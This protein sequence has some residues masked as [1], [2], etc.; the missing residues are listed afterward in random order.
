MLTRHFHGGEGMVTSKELMERT[1]ISRATINNYIALGIL[2][3]AELRR[4]SAA[5]S[6]AP[7]IGYFPDKAIETV[8]T[9]RRLRAEG[10]S[11]DE[12]TLLLKDRKA[13]K[14]DAV[15]MAVGAPASVVSLADHSPNL[16]R[17]TLDQLDYP[18]Y[19]VNNNFEVE[20]WNGYAEEDLFGPDLT[21]NGDIS[22][23]SV[24]KLLGTRPGLA[25]AESWDEILD[26]HFS[27]AKN[28]MPKKALLQLDGEVEAEIFDSLVGAYDQ[29]EVDS[30]RALRQ[31][32][33]N[34]AARADAPRA[35]NLYASFFREGVFLT[36]VPL[37]A[38]RD[39]LLAFLSRRDIV[40]REL[41]KSRRPYL[42]PLAVLVADLQ[43]S[44]RICSELPPE[45]YFE[46]INSIWSVME[47]KLR[48]F[49]ATHGKHVGDGMVY[50]FFP[51]PDS[52]Y[53]QNALTCAHEMREA[54]HD[55]S[56]EWQGRKNW[57]TE[58]KLNIGLDEGEEW[59]GTYQ[60]PTHL[61]FTVLGDTINRAARL[62]DFARDGSL[63]VTK[64]FLSRLPAKQRKSVHYG[65]RRTGDGG[66]NVFVPEVYSRVSNLIDL[67][68]PRFEK[69][70]DIAVLPVTEVLNLG[71]AD[72]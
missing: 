50:Y 25:Q 68:N 38:D 48:K 64:N 49:Y 45:E 32:V 3:R 70:Q 56:R 39:G 43:S 17:L 18:A 51:Q 14:A 34:L 40:I 42:T 13:V 72:K 71:P 61:E 66:E 31:T 62:S 36:Y 67:G 9:V 8:E 1:G 46:L 55:I 53:V 47:P 54:M 19:L 63:W 65:I 37:D 30:S 4:P 20:W 6:T 22:E 15:K 24:F 35:Y 33:V 5:D 29:A 69:L 10:K 26:F 16:V 58:L 41:L 27:I 57:L 44:V 59:F 12:I 11:M 21:A 60:T 52:D 7:R 2:P 23:R 28:R